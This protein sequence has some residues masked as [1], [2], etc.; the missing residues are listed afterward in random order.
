MNHMTWVILASCLALGACAPAAKSTPPVEPVQG[1]M[2]APVTV[3]TEWG[4]RSARVTLRFNAPASDVRVS[5][6]GVDGLS[7]GGEPT[8][9]EGARFDT[10]A[11]AH[12]DVAYTPGKGCSH[13]VV[14]VVGSFQG[15]SL[16]RVASFA[17][18]SPTVEQQRRSGSVITDSEGERIKVMPGGER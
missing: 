16:S 18:G 8:L 17:V 10:G 1:K 7:V 5:V 6:R 3:R 15:T 2:E 4:E 14:A 13:L 11:T 9:V 12:F